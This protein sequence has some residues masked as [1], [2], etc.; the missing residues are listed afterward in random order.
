[1]G[2]FYPV[3]SGFD[4]VGEGRKINPRVDI[5]DSFVQGTINN[6]GRSLLGGLHG[7]GVKR[8]RPQVRSLIFPT[9]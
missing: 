9:S 2:E 5:R 7:T 4:G 1:V 3:G 6:W 8:Q